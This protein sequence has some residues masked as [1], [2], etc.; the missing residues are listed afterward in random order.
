MTLSMLHLV[1]SN[2]S[3]HENRNGILE[4]TSNI[5]EICKN[6]EDSELVKNAIKFLAMGPNNDL[7]MQ[8]GK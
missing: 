8:K 5:D 7:K 6:N 2:T 3:K 4:R 1:C